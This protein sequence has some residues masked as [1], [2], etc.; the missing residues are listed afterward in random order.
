MGEKDAV[1]TPFCTFFRLFFITVFG[2]SPSQSS[3]LLYFSGF[4]DVFF[5]FLFRLYFHFGFSCILCKKGRE[6]DGGILCFYY[7]RL[8][9]NSA[10]ALWGDC[11]PP[12]AERRCK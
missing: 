3:V 11:W 12:L 10:N 6:W 9:S 1:E 4:F 7:T 2:G 5:R 8:G